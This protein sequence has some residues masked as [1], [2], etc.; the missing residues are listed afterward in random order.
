MKYRNIPNETIRRLPIYMRALLF[1]KEQGRQSISSQDLSRFIGTN[2]AQIRKDFSY[3]GDFGTKGVGY[4]I[5]NLVKEI[6]KI[7]KLDID[8]RVALVGVG[9]LGSAVIAYP[10][11]KMFGFDIT[12]AF[13]IDPKKISRKI[14]NIVI[15]NISKIPSLRDKEINLAIIAVPRQAAQEMTDA[16]VK[17]GVTG[18][19]N[20]SPCYITVPKK[21]K[22]I[23]IDI[24]MDLARL[25]Y[26]VPAS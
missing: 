18:I 6:K 7:L 1:S 16:L 13:D 23:T 20:F 25:P 24:A 3:F 14:K 15:E 17:A 4:N 21:V 10:G 11:F 9:N 22:V 5:D 26:Y 19:L 8:K 2:S 12:A